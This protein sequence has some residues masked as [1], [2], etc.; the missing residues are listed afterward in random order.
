MKKKLYI[1]LPE[2]LGT[3]APELYGH[4]S[5]HIGGVFYDGLWVGP[6]SPIPNIRGFRRAA[7]EKLREMR[8]PVLRWPGGCF[9]ETYDWRDGIG[10]PAFRPVRPNWWTSNDGRYEPNLVGTHE[11]L[12]LCELIGAKP[13]F[14]VNVTSLPPLSAR[15]WVDYCLSPRGA[16]TLALEREK[17]G[18]PEPFS[19]PYW[20]VGNENWGGGGNMSP[21]YYTDEYRRYATVMDNAARGRVKLIVGGA[22]G[23]DYGWTRVLCDQMRRAPV[24]GMSFHYYCGKSGG[25][26]DFSADDWNVLIEKA[27]RMGE[28]IDRHYATVRGYGMQ[29]KMRLVIDEW[30]C[31][32]PDGSGPS[33]G[34][35]LFEQQSTM[36]DAVITAL[37]LNIFN[38]NCGKVMM[39]NA[40]QVCNNLH[41]CFLA[42]GEHFIVTPTFHVF[43]MFRDHQGAAALRTVTEDLDGAAGDLSRSV[44]ASATVKDG[45]ITVTLANLSC[46][47][48][49]EIDL[50]LLGGELPGTAQV[51]LLTADDMHAHNTFDRPDAVTPRRFAAD[52]GEPFILPRASVA[53]IQFGGEQEQ[54]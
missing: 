22:N 45:K 37:T 11:F 21:S 39:A 29:D 19:I 7:V 28:L 8:V 34:G 52:P 44:S 53:A 13:Y 49:A 46:A 31:W 48:D 47:E 32:H 20:G 25:A 16:T 4:F 15:D 36:R 42:G 2:S 14:A 50:T 30:G 10:D 26:V 33:A 9:A 41:C 51:T 1:V 38:N 23:A 35:N 5:E 43:T 12:D 54:P 6:D 40:A 18:H 27:N 17:N 3:V 24:H